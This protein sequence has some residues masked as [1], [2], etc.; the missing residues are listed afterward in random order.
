MTWEM[1]ENGG[2]E[3]GS[4]LSRSA[5]P[6]RAPQWFYVALGDWLELLVRLR[7]V[8]AHT[9]SGRTVLPLWPPPHPPFS[10]LLH[11]LCA[12]VLQTCSCPASPLGPWLCRS[13]L[14]ALLSNP[15][16]GTLSEPLEAHLRVPSMCWALGVVRAQRPG[17]TFPIF[18]PQRV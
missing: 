15:L 4:L 7:S 6:C 10:D 18:G 17:S 12:Q 5:S 8:P 9:S 2:R 3:V 14:L 11:I 13:T 1:R 16:P